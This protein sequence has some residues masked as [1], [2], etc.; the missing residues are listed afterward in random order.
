MPPGSKEVKTTVSSL[1][2][3]N[4]AS[5]GLN[6]S[7]R[8]HYSSIIL[9]GL[10]HIY[11]L[12]KAHDITVAIFKMVAIASVDKNQCSQGDVGIFHGWTGDAQWTS[13]AEE[14]CYCEYV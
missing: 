11:A 14:E 9:V 5:A 1:R 12:N 10:G 6:I 3:D 8:L 7:R 4:I 13:S 2:L